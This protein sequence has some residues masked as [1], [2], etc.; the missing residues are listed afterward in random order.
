[1]KIFNVTANDVNIFSM[2]QCDCSNPRKII[3]KDGEFP[4]YVIPAGVNLNCDK[5]Y[6][7]TPKGDFPFPVKG[8]VEFLYCDPLPKGYDVYVVSNLYRSA[9][10]SLMGD[11][12][13]LATI[14]GVVYSDPTNPRP[15]GCLGL[16]IG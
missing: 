9:Y 6:K 4:V 11:T 14:D 1:M 5:D 10:Q 12:S 7:P 16:A 15:C 3:V 2:E 8:A 13:K